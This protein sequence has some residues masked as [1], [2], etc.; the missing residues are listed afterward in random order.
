MV[1]L[2]ISYRS[3]LF[4]VFAVVILLPIT[5]L[6]LVTNAYIKNRL[7]EEKSEIE[8]I[9]IAEK[10]KAYEKWL[11]EEKRVLEHLNFS[12]KELDAHYYGTPDYFDHICAFLEEIK[13][14]YPEILNLYYTLENGESFNSAYSVS[15]IDLTKR[16]WYVGAKRSG[17]TSWTGPYEDQITGR[18]VVTLSKP[19]Y[20]EDNRLIGVCGIDIA[21]DDMKKTI[22]KLYEDFQTDIILY[23]Y[24]G[25]IMDSFGEFNVKEQSAKEVLNQIFSGDSSEGETK[26]GNQTYVYG[27]Y[28]MNLNGWRVISL[29]EKSLYYE[30]YKILNKFVLI[31]GVGAVL[32]G[33]LAAIKFSGKLNK[34]LAALQ[35]SAFQIADKKYGFQ[36]KERYNDEFGDV[37]DAFNQMSISLAD[38]EREM[39]YRNAQMEL[40]NEELLETNVELKASYEQ[41]HAAIK[42][43]DDSEKR[44]RLLMNNIHD[45]VLLLD[46]S[47]NINYV[48]DQV[49]SLFGMKPH[50]VVG[51]SLVDI[52]K[53]K[54]FISPECL[55]NF[56]SEAAQRNVILKD[57]KI[58]HQDFHT[59]DAEVSTKMVSDLEKVNYIQIV[60]RDI[61]KRK[62]MEERLIR[63]NNALNTINGI[64]A[65]IL[66]TMTLDQLLHRVVS[67]LVEVMKL[68]MVVIR[69][70][71]ED[72]L[73]LSAYAGIHEKMI[74]RE[75]IHIDEDVIGKA[76][77]EKRPLLL[78]KE[79]AGEDAPFATAYI[80]K[81][82]ANYILF[83]PIHTEERV[84]GV[85]TATLE[86]EPDLYDDS[87]LQAA[88]HQLALR[89]E[90]I[91]LLENVKN[92]YFS[93]INALIAA[94]EAKDKYTQG[95]SHR[96]SRLSLCLAENLNLNEVQKRDIEVGGMLHDI[97][98][99]GIFDQILN[100]ND[101]LDG[102]EYEEIK[103]HPVIGRKII[104]G[105]QFGQTIEEII[106]LHHKRFDLKGYPE[107]V[108][109]EKLPIGAAIVEVA[110]ALDAMTSSR[111]YRSARPLSEAVDEILRNRG[112][113]FHPEVVDTLLDI[114]QNHPKTL[115]EI[116]YKESKLLV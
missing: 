54:G 76:I 20:D 55:E 82:K 107:E 14:G 12:A 84:F 2:K 34:P 3:K 75:E 56:L 30:N 68:P 42:Q 43:L 110:D 93:T 80:E 11:N 79:E 39:R 71:N 85:M 25:Q 46:A 63:R 26:Y 8:K 90:N 59:F 10:L 77:K 24:E 33:L 91:G 92:S 94:E 41:L 4:I 52:N 27:L 35:Q 36:L 109:L 44:Y 114:W 67:Q 61:T 58:Q 40:R 15:E 53:E 103:K 62:E 100:K 97:G 111:S 104:D 50:E 78:S 65:S 18:Q 95:H 86:S 60:V 66:H 16:D 102:A 7:V 1:K 105:C 48:S 57:T 31:A 88:G 113:Q 89:L 22:G 47:H 87:I 37:V 101:T 108:V 17:F 73:V 96:V 51:K 49:F 23:N 32:I 38:Y 5:V 99:I 28:K 106:L 69:L 29:K 6:G 116:L 98:K 45:M 21:Y 64:S 112:G 13:A 115:N 81:T 70:L 72:K 83:I 19:L 74:P 9:Y